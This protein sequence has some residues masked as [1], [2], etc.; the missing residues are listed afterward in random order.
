MQ[1]C[2]GMEM[3]L[4]LFLF[5]ALDEYGCLNSFPGHFTPKERAT[6]AHWVI[7]RVDVWPGRTLPRREEFFR[8]CRISVAQYERLVTAVTGVTCW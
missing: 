7:D 5:S 4:H 1:F 8:S 2:V 3:E 6:G